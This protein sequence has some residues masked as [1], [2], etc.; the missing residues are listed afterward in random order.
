MRPFDNMM[1][2]ITEAC[3]LRCSYC[4]EQ[5]SSYR[6]RNNMTWATAKHA[7]DFFFAQV[8]P[9]MNRTH[10]TFFGGEPTL[11]FGLIRQVVA[12]SYS[13]RY[14]SGQTIFHVA[15]A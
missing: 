3:N 13:H 11:A 15:Q 4:Y 2:I 10:I 1:L 9:K 12:Y 8:S 7:V 5:S 6:P 14:P